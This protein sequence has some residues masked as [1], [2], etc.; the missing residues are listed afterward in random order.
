MFCQ[1][2][3]RYCFFVH[4]PRMQIRLFRRVPDIFPYLREKVRN[5]FQTPCFYIR[6]KFIRITNPVNSRGYQK[7]T[8]TAKKHTVVILDNKVCGRRRGHI[9]I[10]LYE[11]F[12]MQIRINPESDLG[13]LKR[14]IF[15]PLNAP[16]PI[17]IRFSENV[18]S[19]KAQ[20]INASAPILSALSR[21]MPEVPR[22]PTSAFLPILMTCSRFMLSICQEKAS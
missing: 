15:V 7:F 8:I 13:S 2:I 5:N 10:A 6:R 20:P 14:S 9:I 3:T 17:D 21:D 12:A 22:Y 4:Q 11:L 19:E 1:L 16:S 18:I